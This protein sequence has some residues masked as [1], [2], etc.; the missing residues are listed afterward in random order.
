[1]VGILAN[2]A[3]NGNSGIYFSQFK[4][5]N[6]LCLDTAIHRL[7]RLSLSAVGEART[8]ICHRCRRVKQIK[9][10]AGENHA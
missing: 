10:K 9:A 3:L 6:H 5:V 4:P 7:C 2:R 1:V 8:L